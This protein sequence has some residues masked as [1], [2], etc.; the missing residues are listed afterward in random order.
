MDE[1]W[2]SDQ[3]QGLVGF[4]EAS[5]L[6]FVLFLARSS[7]SAQELTQKLSE[8]DEAFRRDSAATLSFAKG[9]RTR[10]GLSEPVS[11]DLSQKKY[12]LVVQQDDLEARKQRKRERKERKKQRK[13]QRSEEESKEKLERKAKRKVKEEETEHERLLREYN[14]FTG[15]GEDGKMEDE[16]LKKRTQE[17]ETEKREEQLKKIQEESEKLRSQFTVEELKR[18]SRYQY[19]KKR[20]EREIKLLK[21]EI[22][23]EEELFHDAKLTE[24]EKRELYAKKKLLELIESRQE[25]EQKSKGEFYQLPDAYQDQEGRFNSKE[26]EELLHQRYQEEGKPKTEQEVWEE[27][28][29]KLAMR[30]SGANQKKN[31]QSDE[32]KLVDAID[33]ISQDVLAGLNASKKDRKKKRNGAQEV[34]N[35]N[36]N[37]KMSMKETRESLPIFAYRDELLKAVQNHQVLV[38][39]GETG[40]GKTTQ[41]PQYL[42][43][44]G[45]SELGKIGC[46]Q[47]RR[48]AAMSVAARVAQEIGCK[49]GHEVGYSIRFEDCTSERTII[50]YMTDGMLLREF[51]TAPDLADYSVM[52]I[53]EAHERGLNTD[54][55]FGLIKDIAKYR[56]DLRVIVSSATLDAQKFAKY[57]D[58]AP[59]F[60]IPGRRY[61]VTIMYTKAPEADYLDAAVVTTL[62]I[63]VN[64]P[65]PGDILIFLTGQEE[66]EAAKEILVQQT[67]GLG[68]KIK[69][70]IICPIYASLPSEEQ[71]KVFVPT[72]RGAR[73]VVLATNIAE[74]SL[75]IDGICYVI[76]TGFCKQTNYN[77]RTGMDSLMVLP[78]SQAGAMQ[79]SG[80]A[81]RTAP[82]K[83][84]RLYTAWSFKHEMDENTAPEIQRSNLASVVLMLKS[85]GIHNLIHFDFMDPPPHETLIRCLEQLYALGALTDKGELTKVGRR[86]AEFPS[87]PMLSKMLLAAEKYGCVEQILTISA[88]LDANA[89]V[90]YRPKEKAI[91]ADTAKKAFAQGIGVFG[92]HMVLKNVYEQWASAN[93]STSWCYEN[94]VQIRSLRRARDVREQLSELCDRVE[95]ERNSD[96]DSEKIRKAITAGYFY[97]TAKMK[98]DGSYKTV[99]NQ[100]TVHIHPSSSLFKVEPPPKYVIYHQLQYTKLEYMRQIVVINPDWLVEIAPHLYSFDELK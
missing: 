36:K 69:E 24:K 11:E 23:D 70:L 63:H 99:K 54:I 85:L 33:F 21:A 72:P 59:I 6:A 3:L 97:H 66:I 57:F 77:A 27:Q 60:N 86:M 91:H 15:T 50:K 71:A 74:T 40:S 80:R 98:K 16:R 2:V 75:T 32:Y 52:M 47:P 76:D 90:F 31:Q 35:N 73:K 78:I 81:G 28:Q 10:L 95:L 55:L 20:E 19:L 41:I 43:E 30:Q 25:V 8:S 14:E 7:L 18:E 61:P 17:K 100:F 48:V 79:R 56:K 84:F 9:L 65:I 64:E 13:R 39:V 12:S 4:S 88:M 87:D 45:Y 44:A 53:D 94:F 82:G 34:D 49:V 26:K 37:N 93:Y 83:C 38:V 89:A 92:D 1:T 96:P 42:H 68:T 67:R 46:T 5:T 62:Q 22:L 29:T 51:M 58:D